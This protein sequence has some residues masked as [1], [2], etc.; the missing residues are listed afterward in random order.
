M[1]KFDPISH[2]CLWVLLLAINDSPLV[3]SESITTAVMSDINSVNVNVKKWNSSHYKE[4]H[5]HNK[6]WFC[7]KKSFSIMTTLITQTNTFEDCGSLCLNQPLTC[8]NFS[9]RTLVEG[10]NY[11]G[12]QNLQSTIDGNF[13]GSDLNSV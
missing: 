7:S 13:Q 5:W 12:T 9:I 8:N 11:I 2:C 1:F 6:C 10:V 4:M 3:S